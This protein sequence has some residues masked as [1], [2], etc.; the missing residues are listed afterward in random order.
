MEFPL[1]NALS[2][3]NNIHSKACKDGLTHN[4]A[5]RNKKWIFYEV[6][7]YNN[8]FDFSVLHIIKLGVKKYKL[9]FPCNDYKSKNVNIQYMKKRNCNQHKIR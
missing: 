6:K 5:L 1:R 8:F 4:K 7:I 2:A 3:A 9:Q